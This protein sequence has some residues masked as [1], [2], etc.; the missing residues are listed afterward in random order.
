MAQQLIESVLPMA[1]CVIRLAC[2]T[3]SKAAPTHQAF[4]GYLFKPEVRWPDADLT[5]YFH[6]LDPDWEIPTAI[7]KFDPVEIVIMPGRS[8]TPVRM[9]PIS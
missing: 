6:R 9:Q 1:A 8:F 2:V 5:A 4:F 3:Q 7:R